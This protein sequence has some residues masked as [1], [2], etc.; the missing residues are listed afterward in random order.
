MIVIFQQFIKLLSCG[1]SQIPLQNMLQAL[2]CV[3]SVTLCVFSANCGIV[4]AL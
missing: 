3:C 2:V 1:I 4:A